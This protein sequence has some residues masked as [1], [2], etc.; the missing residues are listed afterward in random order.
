ML[1]IARLLLSEERLSGCCNVKDCLEVKD[2]F[3]QDCYLFN[4]QVKADL[5]LNLL[6]CDNGWKRLDIRQ[7]KFLHVLWVVENRGHTVVLKE[8]LVIFEEREMVQ[9]ISEG[10]NS[11]GI[12]FCFWSGI[13]VET[14]VYN[15]KQL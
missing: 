3:E 14:V 10:L 5:L 6:E 8:Q 13:G 2:D 4:T 9:E 7:A 1:S 15:L 12:F 11:L